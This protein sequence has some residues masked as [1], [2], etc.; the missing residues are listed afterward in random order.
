MI[1]VKLW[2]G[3][4]NQMFQ[5]AFGYA[6]ARKY[7]D[8]LFFDI[9]FFEAQPKKCGKREVVLDKYFNI[10][11]IEKY[12]RTK[13]ISFLENKY[14]NY[15]I[16]RKKGFRC[17][18]PG[19]IMFFK[20]KPGCYYDEIPYQSGK[21]NYYDGYWQSENY[22]KEY[23]DELRNIFS[24]NFEIGEQL[25]KFKDELVENSTAL[26]IRRGDY[27]N[28]NNMPGGYTEKTILDYYKRAIDLVVSKVEKNTFYVFSDD[29]NW[30]KS[31]FNE[32]NKNLS[33]KYIEHS[34]EYAAPTDLFS[35]S[36]CKHGIMSPSTFSWWGNW[37]RVENNSIVIAPKGNYSNEKFL[38]NRWTTC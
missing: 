5:Y 25:K 34:G 35:I 32:N 8:D 2:G 27:L 30:C 16:R 4:C 6:M 10:N 11:K 14:I 24:P 36:L 22:F 17:Y 9:D 29:I 23:C 3:M 19:N 28:S 1:V 21:I 13:S 7:E 33:F 20:E 18:L 26:H 15:I 38:L 31:Y 12:S 37:L